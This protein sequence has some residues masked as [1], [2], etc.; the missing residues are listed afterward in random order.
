MEVA[1]DVAVYGGKQ[2]LAMFGYAD[3]TQLS[4]QWRFWINSLFL[5][6]GKCIVGGSG[7]FMP[8]QRTQ[9]MNA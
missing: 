2:P 4:I 9:D 5:L 7:Q 1:V 3:T 6:V 8:N